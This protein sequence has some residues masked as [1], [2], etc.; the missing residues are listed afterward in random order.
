MPKVKRAFSFVSQNSVLIILGL[1]LIAGYFLT[2]IVNL[3]II[4][5][6]AD[7]AIYIRWAQVMRAVA[8]LRFLPLSDGKQPLFMWGMIPFL[9]I[10]ADPLFAG[11]MLS[12]LAGLG[13]MAG[14]FSLSLILFK[15]KTIAF[16]A[17]LFYLICPFCLFFDRMALADGLLSFFGVWVLAGGVLLA[18][19]RRLD[20]AMGVGIFLGLALLTKSPALFFALML[21]V[22][23]LLFGL[24]GQKGKSKGRKIIELL[25]LFSLWG[26][27]Y[28]FGLAIYNILRLGPEFHMIAARNK[29]YV[30]SFSEVLAHPLNPLWGNLKSA[31]SWYW[32]MLTP[33][34][35]LAGL[36]GI[37]LGLKKYPRQTLVLGLWLAGPLLAQSAIAK[38]YTSRYILF[39]VPVFLVFSA[40]LTAEIF[41][42][43]KSKWITVVVLILV[44]IWPIYQSALLLSA[45]QRAWLPDNE[46]EGYLE[47]WT[48]GYGIR[49]AAEYLKAVSKRHKVL[50][51]TE[52]YFGTLPDGLQIYLEGVPNITIIGIGQP[53]R[54][55]PEKLTNGL[56]ENR[57]FLLV[58]DSRIFIR[59]DIHLKPVA[60][61]AKAINLA[62][63][64][65]E[66][67]LLFEVIK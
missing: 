19:Q 25:G 32:M 5:V 60:S 43:L 27:I 26:I 17:S 64:N 29:D 58:N 40:F 52:G 23:V 38:V 36:G 18:R 15:N 42:R 63:G 21:P 62:S 61:Y 35:F 41:T 57:V 51:G 37:A 24:E 11:R 28:L 66:N 45:P 6:F 65:Q 1:L 3:T 39:T 67:L 22:T 44:F 30:F 59:S 2:R 48:A 7:E 50:V 47:K 34:V 12:V 14:V 46:R 8:S 16:F 55:I 20:L 13:T 33:L 54:E 10:F 53:V 4:P 9:K 49:E 56:D 31:V